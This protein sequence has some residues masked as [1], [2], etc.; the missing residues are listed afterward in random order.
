LADTLPIWFAGYTKVFAKYGI[1]VTNEMIAKDVLGDW[2]G[3]ERLGITKVE[4]FL[5]IWRQK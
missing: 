3:P 2:Q 4:E 1:A 5:M